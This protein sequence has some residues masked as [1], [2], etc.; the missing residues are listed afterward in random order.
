M[1]LFGSLGSDISPRL[2]SQSA[3]YHPITDHMQMAG[4]R[5]QDIGIH[6]F[7][8]YRLSNVFHGEVL[9]RV[10]TMQVQTESVSYECK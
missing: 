5:R 7:R 4:M 2:A 10:T 6:R 1:Y 9:H 8:L 3:G